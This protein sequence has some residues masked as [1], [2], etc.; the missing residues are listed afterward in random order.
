MKTT[1]KNK[2]MTHAAMLL[3]VALGAV[4]AQAQWARVTNGLPAQATLG[5]V[6]RIGTTLFAVQPI[7]IGTLGVFSSTND[8]TSW[9]QVSRVA[10]ENPTIGP[11]IGAR[12]YV[13]GTTLLLTTTGSG[14]YRSTNNGVTWTQSNAGL[15]EATRTVS[16]LLA[17]P[18]RVLIGTNA[19]VY[20]STNNGQSWAL[21]NQGIP[22]EEGRQTRIRAFALGANN[23]VIAG[24][25]GGAYRSI[26]NG[27][28][29]TAIN[30]GL[31]VASPFPT[32]AFI[33]AL[34]YS[35]T[36][37]FAAATSFVPDLN[38]IF[39]SAD[40]GT[41]WTR[42]SGGRINQTETYTALAASGSTVFVTVSGLGFGRLNPDGA[43]F[44]STNNG[45]AWTRI[46]SGIANAASYDFL[47]D[48]A[49]VFVAGFDG[50]Y[51]STNNGD[52]WTASNAGLEP[53]LEVNKFFQSGTSLFIGT[54]FYG[55]FRSTDNGASWSAVNNGL[56]RTSG[57]ALAILDFAL[58]GGTLIAS[59]DS[60][61]YRSTNNGDAWTR[62]TQGL[63]SG[64]TGGTAPLAPMVSIG[65][66]VLGYAGGDGSNAIQELYRSTDNGATWS[67]SDAGLPS[68]YNIVS[69]AVSGTR[70]FAGVLSSGATAGRAVWTSTDN[71]QNWT[72][73]A[74]NEL[75]S[76]PRALTAS[77]N[78]LYINGSGFL[79][80]MSRSTDNGATWTPLNNSPSGV[81]AIAVSGTT[82]VAVGLDAEANPSLFVSSN[83]GDTWIR[84]N[85]GLPTS[86]ALTLFG[87]VGG[88]A[89]LGSTV[90]LAYRL[91]TF[92]GGGVWRREVS[93][94]SVREIAGARPTEFKLD[95]NYPNPFN[96]ST[97]ISYQLP[98]SG[99]VKLV[100]Y[101][102]LGREVQTLVNTRQ[103]AG[104][105]QATF[106]A[107]T[108]SSG[109]YFYR[110]SAG[111]LSETKKMMLVK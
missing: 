5:A 83:S 26:D 16:A 60:G 111:Q 77:G 42:L 37:L 72:A 27:A 41:T 88:L 46:T 59:T 69:F 93:Q 58:S 48:G 24:G 76:L 97:V 57:R 85:S 73:T 1:V 51:R 13:S 86:E 47:I 68:G 108:L 19:G 36:T 23:S 96:P 35:G 52:S 55:A 103:N 39:R 98:T 100:V 32:A 10:V 82:V 84:T 56:T 74:Y 66:V 2:V 31:S 102:M 91:D 75:G 38:G 30:A 90:Y 44:R 99:D 18:N 7:G 15:P 79:G 87:S 95:Q 63:P 101:D 40:N 61:V 62:V 64:I 92:N 17:L 104:R 109:A 110:L 49:R 94:L 43:V 78:T 22:L 71:G 65:N 70:V 4:T 33:S 29:W 80:R 106:N 9:T 53:K 107:A 12:I 8:G 81:S 25:D 89:T 50:I 105:Y 21:S 11:D 34:A 28:T 3:F 6:T 54:S 67:V 20:G 45:D 14:V